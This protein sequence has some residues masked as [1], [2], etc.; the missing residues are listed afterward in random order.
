MSIFHHF[1]IFLYIFPGCSWLVLYFGW[2][3][4]DIPHWIPVISGILGG[5]EAGPSM[6]SLP[7]GSSALSGGRLQ[8]PRQI[9]LLHLVTWVYIYYTLYINI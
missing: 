6:W 7:R 5:P 1:S 3:P 9:P 4:K 2:F 8:T